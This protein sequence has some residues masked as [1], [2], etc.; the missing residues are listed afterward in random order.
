MEPIHIKRFSLDF[1]DLHLE[2]ARYQRTQADSHVG[3]SEA[4]VDEVITVDCLTC[5]I[6]QT[7]L[8][9]KQKRNWVSVL[10]LILNLFRLA[11]AAL[12]SRETPSRTVAY[13][14]A[15]LCKSLLDKNRV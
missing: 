1:Q 4:N 9:T 12:E 15:Q 7:C 3:S 10:V 14:S 5:A 11:I 8:Q 13:A 2:L 6:P